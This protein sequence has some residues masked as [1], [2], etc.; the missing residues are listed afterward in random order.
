MWYVIVTCRSLLYALLSIGAV[1]CVITS[2]ATPK[3]LI[4]R[5]KISNLYNNV[6]YRESVGIYNRCTYIN[7]LVKLKLEKNCGIYATSF[8]KIDSAAWQACIVFFGAAIV[9][10]FVAA[11]MAVMAFCKQICYK[12]S[13][14]NLAGVLQAL[15]GLLLAISLVIYPVGWSSERIQRLCWKPVSTGS[16]GAYKLGECDLGISFYF[17]IGGCAGAFFCAVL[18]SIADNSMF[19]DGVQEEILE[20]KNLVCVL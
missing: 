13:V 1:M 2:I 19:S 20:G 17:A 10:L 18:S 3:W 14:L 12:K 6:T 15:A 4:G 9:F 7:N 11:A 16:A 8:P 5:V